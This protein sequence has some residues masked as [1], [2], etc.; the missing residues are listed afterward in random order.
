MSAADKPH[1]K[2]VLFF[3]DGIGLGEDDSEKNPLHGLFGSTTNNV[4]FVYCSEPVSFPDGVLIPADA[5]LGVDGVPQSAT[6]QAS[7]FTGTNAQRL[8]GYHLSAYPNET[9]KNV[10]L[11][12]SLMKVLRKNGVS[13][14]SANLYS[15]EFFE[16]RRQSKK[17]SFPVSTLTIMA[18]E[19]PFR[20]AQDYHDGKAVFADITNEL[21]RKRGFDIPLIDPEKAAKNLLNILHD[22]DFVFF[23]YFMTDFHG[24]KKR[25]IEL[26]EC[27]DILNRFVKTIW[28]DSSF[29]GLSFM[30]VSDHGNA[31]D[32]STGEH[33]LNPVP[34]L[35]LSHE[36]SA[37]KDVLSS[38]NDITDIYSTVVRYFDGS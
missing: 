3:I 12:K 4:P 18:S 8:L 33:T 26:L 37:V 11:E 10:I 19:V 38:V 20:F 35:F 1:R 31:E 30:V 25:R 27:V 7:I 34:V 22:H 16:T 6:G 24:H 15:K 14:T 13:V 5:I 17:N 9:L 21:I 28:S 23:E 2:L 29:P 32:L 36:P